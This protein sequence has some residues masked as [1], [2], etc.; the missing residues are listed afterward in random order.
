MNR[1]I[2][3]MAVLIEFVVGSGLAV[4]FHLVLHNAQAA[5]M[6]FGIGILLSLV[7]YL[8][9]ED[10]GKAKAGLLDQYRQVHEIPFELARITDGECQAKAQEL[11]AGAKRTIALLQQ[12]L[13]PM[14]ETEFYLEGAKLSDQAVRQIRAVD[15]LTT[16][17]LTRGALLN[18]YQSNLRALDRGVRVSRIFVA[19]RQDLVDP[20]VQ[21]ILL[22]QYRDE[23]DVR[24]VFR[25]ELPVIN[26]LSGRDTV[27]SFD[28]AIYDDR[29]VTEVFAK[30]GRYYG[31]KTSQPVEVAKFRHLYD[32]IEHSA[33][34]VVAD[35]DRIS[36]VADVVPLAS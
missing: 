2:E 14:D 15:P 19:N 26:D 12:G 33:H 11:L 5:W 3:E 7:T 31:N 30:A 29:S 25:D 10:I 23:I 9:R 28:F 6:I 18:F 27:S 8:V 22:G 24:I 16:G 17:W 32:I 34:R 21:R 1:K 13:I 35:G 4:F 36:L 20:E